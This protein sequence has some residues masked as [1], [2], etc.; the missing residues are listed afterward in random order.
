MRKPEKLNVA[1]RLN[2]SPEAE[3]SPE[4]KYE[5]LEGYEQPRRVG[6]I[7]VSA[8]VLVSNTHT[9]IIGRYSR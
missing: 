1:L 5:S 2:V 3:R 9:N 6:R 4:A 7:R 8:E